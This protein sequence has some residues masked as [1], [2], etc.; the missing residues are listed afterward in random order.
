MVVQIFPA[1]VAALSTLSIPA[2]GVFSSALLLGEPLNPGE[3]AA[4]SLVVVSLGL[5][6]LSKRRA[7]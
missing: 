5:T 1:S 3:L 6:S 7:G 4:L 2:I